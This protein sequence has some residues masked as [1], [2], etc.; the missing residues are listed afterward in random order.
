MRPAQVNGAI[1]QLWA[2]ELSAISQNRGG[3][4]EMSMVKTVLATMLLCGMAFGQAPAALKA[5][6]A[7]ASS[8]MKRWP[9]G[10]IGTTNGPGHWGYEEG[11]LLDGIAAEWHRTGNR[12]K[13]DY[14]RPRSTSM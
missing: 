6:E 14:I 11:V 5:N 9:T 2:F 7:M 8:A 12:A 1:Y 10:A 13:F 4:K 3:K